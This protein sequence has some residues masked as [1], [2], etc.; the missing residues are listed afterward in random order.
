MKLLLL[1]LLNWHLRFSRVKYVH[2]GEQKMELNLCQ[3][4]LKRLEGIQLLPVRVERMEKCG[5]ELSTVQARWR[6]RRRLDSPEDIGCED[7]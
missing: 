6:S 3:R 7:I 2:V 5:V 4:I 1:E